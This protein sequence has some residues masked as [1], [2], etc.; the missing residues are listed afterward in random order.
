M[1]WEVLRLSIAIKAK[2]LRKVY[3]G[4]PPVVAL[5]SAS[6]DITDNEFFT[7]LGPSG[8]GKTTLLRLI[9]GFE[10]ITDGDLLLYGDDISSLPPEKRP[11]NTVFQHYSLFPHM[12]ILENVAFGLRRLGKAKAEANRTAREMLDLVQLAQMADRYPSQLSGGQQQRVALARALAPKPR[13]LL[14]DEP[15]SALDLKL[16]QAMRSEL[17]RLQRETGI[18]FVF[19]THDQE[20]AL[21]MSDRIAVMSAGEIQ[22]IATPDE[23]YENPTNRFVA[24]FIGDAN[25]YDVVLRKTSGDTAT[26]ETSDG[27]VL[28]G[29]VVEGLATGEAATLFVRPE[30]VTLLDSQTTGAVPGTVKDVIYLGGSTDYEVELEH[31]ATIVVR[32]E[33]HRDG[34]TLANPGE[35]VFVLIDP[36]AARVLKS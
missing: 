33:N 4:R 29:P 14:L 26:Y 6:V 16:R 28:T 25:F 30:K 18:T 23:I 12:T 22:Q 21:S 20:E 32:A 11:I 1:H 3:D 2:G 24:D 9:A 36:K 7:L 35:Q 31:G 27:E 19:V 13:V 17:K 5:S 10:A 8:C 34:S 15:L